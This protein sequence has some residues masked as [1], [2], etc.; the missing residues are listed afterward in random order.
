MTEPNVERGDMFIVMA[1]RHRG[2][3]FTCVGKI[4]DGFLAG[5]TNGRMW[6]FT[7]FGSDEYRVKMAQGPT[8]AY[9]GTIRAETIIRE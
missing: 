4:D 7:M 8:W 5:D 2:N 3:H 9:R 1:D 6:K